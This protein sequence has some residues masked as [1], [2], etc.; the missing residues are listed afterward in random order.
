M[1][2]ASNDTGFGA[3]MMLIS[4]KGHKIYCVIRFG[5]KT[6]NNKAKYEAL[7]ADLH[8]AKLQVCNVKIFSDS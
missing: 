6:S 7:I 1:D 8:L 5:F 4:L 2:N 3:S